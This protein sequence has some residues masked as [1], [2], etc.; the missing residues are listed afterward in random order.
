MNLVKS[1]L[2]LGGLAVGLLVP[3]MMTLSNERELFKDI[4]RIPLMF[5]GFSADNTAAVV[6]GVPKAELSNFLGGKADNSNGSTIFMPL[7][8]S[9]LPRERGRVCAA[10]FRRAGGFRSQAPDPRAR[11]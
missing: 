11:P 8:T 3:T 10:L 5:D 7:V 9:K 1:N 2:I 6:I 4:A